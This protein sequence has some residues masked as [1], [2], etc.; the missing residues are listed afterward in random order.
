[1]AREKEEA[2]LGLVSFVYSCSLLQWIV[3]ACAGCLG[4]PVS[5]DDLEGPGPE[6]EDDGTDA[7]VEGSTIRTRRS[8]RPSRPPPSEGRGGQIN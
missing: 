6:E 8:R 5:C 7:R 4:F 1:M 3:N 2:C